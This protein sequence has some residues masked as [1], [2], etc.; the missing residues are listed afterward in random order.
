MG[1]QSFEALTDYRLHGTL[2]SGALSS[3]KAAEP[4]HQDITTQE[5]APVK[6]SF[7]ISREQLTTIAYRAGHIM[8]DHFTHFGMARDVKG[9]K[10]PVTLADT[11]IN[12]MFIERVREI[13]PHI[14][15]VGEEESCRKESP[16]QLVVDPVDGTFPFTWGMPV[17]TF[18]AAL[19]FEGVPVI[20]V[21]YD[22]FTDRMF[23]AERGKGAHMNGRSLRVSQAA[24]RGERPIVG[25]VSWPDSPYNVLKVMHYLEERGITSINLCSIG[26]I[27][28]AVA[29]GELAGTVFPGTAHH[30]TAPGHIIVDEAGGRVTDVHGKLL[31]YEGG[32][33]AG[34]VMSNGRIHEL[35]MEALA[36]CNP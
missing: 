5:G 31:T 8:R 15:V 11:L 18:M 16:W 23:S 17:A 25:Y 7:P 30:D 19:L 27:E 34:H 12:T 1:L 32:K 3:T 6:Q 13:A 2:H 20:G 29:T 22:P 26:Y 21:I 24:T 33:I 14:D 9:D 10:T 36:A 4:Q 28:V 35:L